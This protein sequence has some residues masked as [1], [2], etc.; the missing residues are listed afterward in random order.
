MDTPQPIT[1]VV[2]DGAPAERGD[3]LL[4]RHLADFSRAELQRIF[5]AGR[6]TRGDE[7]LT[8]KTRLQAGDELEI[9]PLPQV[10]TA[11]EPADI[12][13][14]V[15]FEDAHLIAI[16]KPAGMV[17]HPGNGTGADTLVHALLHHCGTQLSPVGAPERPG[18]VHRL[19]KE[20]SGVI[21]VAKT[22]A[23]HHALAEQFQSRRTYKEYLAIA[24]GIPTLASGSIKEPIGRHPT[25]RTR[26]A[27]TP[28]GRHAHTDW[29]LE[30]PLG[31]HAARL[32]CI[33]HTGRTHQIRVHLKHLGH[34]ILGDPTYGRNQPNCPPAPRVML[35]AHV[36]E[37]DHPKTGERLRF[38]A[39]P[40]ADFLAYEA[41]LRG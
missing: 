19:D 15:L 13:L 37:I 34:P 2:P 24:S 25:Q 32:R 18:I 40:P 38:T 28:G 39:E 4:A 6:V 21:V 12:P 9:L 10:E 29:R 3:K 23:A 16:D 5:E 7:I 41:I 17:T 36:L 30:N 33:I 31:E 14:D 1:F 20:T 11:I 22:A 26:M 35:H 27:I 8:Q